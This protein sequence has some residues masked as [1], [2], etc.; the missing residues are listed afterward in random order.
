MHQCGL[1]GQTV[2]SRKK[3][4]TE[5]CKHIWLPTRAT[6]KVSDLC[7]SPS[8]LSNSRGVLLYLGHV[9]IK[10]SMSAWKLLLMWD[11]HWLHMCS[12]Q[13]RDI[14]INNSEPY[15]GFLSTVFYIN[16]ESCQFSRDCFETVLNRL[17]HL[18]QWIRRHTK[19]PI[20]CMFFYIIFTCPP[21]IF[22]S[23]SHTC[24]PFHHQ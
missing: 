23:C 20:I 6:F 11:Y 16:S 4:Y 10:F 12:S 15:R 13:I 3:V 21:L 2:Y 19:T 14:N 8:P 7:L 24:A 18:N 9:Y 5:M 17:L 22:I 1:S